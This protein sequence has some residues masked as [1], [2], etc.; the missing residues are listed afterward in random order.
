[1]EPVHLPSDNR[2]FLKLVTLPWS[3]RGS[4]AWSSFSV[5]QIFKK[6][7]RRHITEANLHFI[8]FGRVL[9]AFAVFFT[10]VPR[11]H[12]DSPTGIGKQWRQAPMVEGPRTEWQFKLFYRSVKRPQGTA[13]A[14]GQARGRIKDGSGWT[15]GR[16]CGAGRRQQLPFAEKSECTWEGRWCL[17]PFFYRLNFWSVTRDSRLLFLFSSSVCQNNSNGP[18]S[19]SSS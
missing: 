9:P 16:G 15:G 1:M 4:L 5:S 12:L 8:S 11:L 13:W 10:H 3:R 2:S 18:Y 19:G 7:F 6:I 14:I 17:P